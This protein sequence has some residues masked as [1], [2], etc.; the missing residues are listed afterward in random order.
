MVLSSAEP[1]FRCKDCTN[2]D[3]KAEEQFYCD[4]AK[5]AHQPQLSPLNSADNER[6][7]KSSMSFLTYK[8]NEM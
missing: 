6:E 7:E 4:V 5:H 2:M 3:M 8:E 1:D